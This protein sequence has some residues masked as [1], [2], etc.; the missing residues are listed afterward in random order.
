MR[1]IAIFR[2]NLKALNGLRVANNVV[3]EDRAVFLDPRGDGFN[4]YM[5]GNC[6]KIK[7]R[8]LPWQVICGAIR[9]R[10]ESSLSC[11]RR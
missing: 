11:R 8:M 6:G 2:N 3:E 4:Y 1:H 7:Q 10:F 5:L 9:T